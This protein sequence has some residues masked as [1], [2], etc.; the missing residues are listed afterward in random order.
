MVQVVRWARRGRWEQMAQLAR[1]RRVAGLGALLATACLLATIGS[2]LGATADSAA[3]GADVPAATYYLAL[4]GSASVGFQPVIRHPHGWPTHT[5]YANDLV[6][7]EHARWPDL[8][9]VDLGCPGESTNTFINGGD[10]CHYGAGSQLQTALSFLSAT[11]GTVLMTVDLGFNDVEPCLRHQVVDQACVDNAI[12]T[13]RD[14]LT[15]ILPM[16]RAA[17]GPDLHIIGVGH[18]DPFLGDALHGAPGLAFALQTIGVITRLNDTLRSTYAAE[19]IPMANVA[20]A[21]EMNSA[22]PTTGPGIGTPPSTVPRDVARVCELTWMCT[23]SPFG[24][25]PHP[26]D[27]G[28]RV[29]SNAIAATIDDT[30][31]VSAGG[32]TN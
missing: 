2:V 3:A 12:A 20:D 15:E 29:I 10:R 6:A 26:N 5:G 28:Y 30:L 32:G 13:T 4:G 18:Y 1:R 14:Q 25:N 23:P 16:L 17:G 11:P 24:P 8:T 22:V 31:G 9:L 27:E 21:F 19:G 7:A